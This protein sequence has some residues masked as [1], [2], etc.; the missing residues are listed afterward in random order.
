M[1]SM[2]RK[3]IPASPLSQPDGRF[4]DRVGDKGSEFMLGLTV[5][6]GLDTK[7][8][9]C[10]SLAVVKNVGTLRLLPIPDAKLLPQSQRCTGENSQDMGIKPCQSYACYQDTKI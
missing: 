8:V 2:Q 4:P 9:S 1:D 3:A 7:I 5:Q 6:A 10:T